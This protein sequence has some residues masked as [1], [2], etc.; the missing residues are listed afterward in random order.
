MSP[1]TEA[2]ADTNTCPRC[3]ARFRCGMEAGDHECWCASLPALPLPDTSGPGSL[4]AASCFCPLCLH[5]LLLQSE[6]VR[7]AA[8]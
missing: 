4:A 6:V 7:S 3:G 5:A 2:G 8:P 1:G